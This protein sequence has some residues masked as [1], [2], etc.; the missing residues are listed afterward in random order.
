MYYEVLK[1]T[2]NILMNVYKT[3]IWCPLSALH[4]YMWQHK[5]LDNSKWN[6]PLTRCFK[7]SKLKINLQLLFMEAAAKASL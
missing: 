1:R 3:S 5:V 2:T 4:C 7:N 6:L